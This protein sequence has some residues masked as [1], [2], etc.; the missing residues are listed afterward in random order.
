MRSEI[1]RNMLSRRLVMWL[2]QVVKFFNKC[3]N[4]F[5]Y[6]QQ[7]PKVIVIIII[8]S[9]GGKKADYWILFLWKLIFSSSS[10]TW[11][12]TTIIPPETN[13][14][15]A[16]EFKVSVS[17]RPTQKRDLIK[18]LT[19]NSTKKKKKTRKLIQLWPQ[20]AAILSW[21]EQFFFHWISSHSKIE[22]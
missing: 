18:F 13:H 12:N 16:N 8:H 7:Q 22:S 19:F 10:D 21:I 14:E 15:A 6:I 17:V 20:D 5:T 11:P 1:R 9:V 4:T 3:L 2:N